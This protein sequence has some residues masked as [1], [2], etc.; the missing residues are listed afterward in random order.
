HDFN[1]LLMAITSY[2]E[3]LMMRL[4]ADSGYKTEVNEILKACEAAASLTR[5][6]LAFSRKQVLE[7]KV[8]DLN[9]IVE[10]MEDMLRRLLREDI[11]LRTVFDPDLGRV[12]VDP[13]QV[14]QVIVNL[15]VNARDALTGIGKVT[16][17]TANVFLEESYARAHMDVSSGS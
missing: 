1:N 16:I 11:D 5:Q 4:P 3:L 12:R 13:G 15:V 10:K 9:E 7:P 6:L 8:V 17:E 2:S 14:Q